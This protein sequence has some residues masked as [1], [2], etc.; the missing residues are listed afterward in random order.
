MGHF[1]DEEMQ[2]AIYNKKTGIEPV[3]MYIFDWYSGS[4]VLF[5]LGKW[6]IG[7]SFEPYTSPDVHLL[8]QI[9]NF[10]TLNVSLSNVIGY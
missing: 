4:A 8:L 2:L 1:I 9:D 7:T 3:E 5:I 10:F 6:P